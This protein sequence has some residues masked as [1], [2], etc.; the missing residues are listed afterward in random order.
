VFHV[1]QVDVIV[2]GGGHAGT[3]AAA[4]A[5][6]LGASTALV[7]MDVARIGVMSCNPAIGGLGKGHLVREVDA[8]DGIMGR[9]AD[10]AGIQFRL[11]NRSKGPAVQ[12]PRAQADRA[13]YRAA[14]QQALAGQPGLEILPGEVIDLM[15][16]AGAVA[17]VVLSDGSAIAARAVVLT[18]GTFLN[19]V[20]HTGD[21]SRP[22]GRVGD[23]A[24]VRLAA[25]LAA[26]GLPRGRLK[27][28]TPPRLAGRSIDWDAVGWQHG[29]A[30]PA[31]LSFLSEGPRLRQVAC[32]ITETSE[33]THAIIRANLHRSAMYGGHIE[34]VGPRY[35]PSIEDKVVRFADRPAHQLFL[36]P[37]GIEDDTIYP[38]GISTSLPAEVQE[39]YVRTIRGL[40]RA[41]IL[42]PG[43]AVEYD[44]FDPRCLGPDLAVKALPGLYLAGQVNGTTGY[45]EA[46]AQGL[47]AGINA[48]RRAAGIEPVTFSCGES[49]IG[50]MID[51]LV[52]RGVSE[53]YRMFTSRAEYRLILRADNAD[54]RLTPR[55]IALGCVGAV[56]ARAFEG[57][58][59]RLAAA[60]QRLR[61]GRHSP[62][63]L[64][65][66]GIAAKADGT[67]RTAFEV[68][69]LPGVT[70]GQLQ[71]LDP[72]LAGID[73]ATIEELRNDAIYAAFAPR[74]EAAVAALRRDEAR[75]IPTGFD[76]AAIAGL[77]N[78]LREKLERARPRSLAQAGGIEGMTPAA[79]TLILAHLRR[80]ELRSAVS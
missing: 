43:Y 64:Q 18:A 26:L 74:Q 9:A 67:L 69:G 46:A 54:R 51:D 4:V 39:S 24:S 45:E 13:Q 44:Y 7:T 73:A 42:V 52:T 19:G 21:V 60:M 40:E 6:R 61:E 76:Y 36:E 49:Y 59:A 57:K 53:P 16:T 48:A 50:V 55:G 75:R 20:I 23:P 38:N 29:D 41:E 63:A 47:A 32:G 22:A 56:R 80:G 17:G 71:A 30:V 1:K 35:C 27:T 70:A 65:R 2:I 5:A 33:R 28:G 31:M 3:E 14:V 10:A 77:S 8:L 66:A 79:L 25:R 58:A 12:G 37:E 15:V 11:L 72:G 34:G 62:Q 78:E 68:L